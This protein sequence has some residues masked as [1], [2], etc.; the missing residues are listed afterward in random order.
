VP[1]VLLKKH[2]DVQVQPSRFGG[3][4]AILSL[5]SRSAR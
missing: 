3:L 5:I 2:G 4:H 1:S